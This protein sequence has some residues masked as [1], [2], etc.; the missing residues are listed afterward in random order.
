[1]NNPS[2]SAGSGLLW[3]CPTSHLD[4]DWLDT[5]AEYFEVGPPDPDD[6]GYVGAAKDILTGVCQLLRAQ[7]DF[8]YSLAEVAYLRAYLAV[9]PGDLATLQ[10]A[11]KGPGPNRFELIGGGI[12]S[13]DNLVCHGEVFIRNYLL[14]RRW[15]E[16][17]G[18]SANVIP[19][20]W[21]PDDFGHDPQLPVV[22]NAMGLSWLG[23]SRV[24]GSIQPFANQPLQPPD[25]LVIPSVADVLKSEG[26]VFPWIASDGSQV[27]THF[28]PATYGAVWDGEPDH[29]GSL[30]DFAESTINGWP[31]VNGIGRVLFAPAGGDFAFAQWDG[32][33][34]Q[35]F[36]EYYSKTKKSG[37]PDAQF[38]TFAQFMVQVAASAGPARSPL[39][40]Q[41][42]WTGIFASRPALKILHNRAAQ[43]T[44]AAEA[45]ATLLRLTGTNST[46]T[47]DDLDAAV[48]Q[49][50]QAL[51][52]S[53]HHDYITGTSPDR[54][55]WGEQLPMLEQAARLAQ[56]SL[57]QAVG[58]IAAGLPAGPGGSTPVAI[59]N[60]V[61]FTRQGGVVE[62]PAESV[63]ASV[64]EVTI[65][66]AG[67]VRIQRAA[68]G[69]LLILLPDNISLDSFGYVTAALREGKEPPAPS[70]PS[71]P[72][73][74]V[75]LNSDRVHVRID[76]SQAWAITQLA[77]PGVPGFAG[78]GNSIRLYEDDGN[79]YQFG[80]EPLKLGVFLK[81]AD[82]GTVLTAGPG[83][84]IEYG[85]VRWHF[86]ATV[87]GTYTNTSENESQ[88]VSY[89]LD[90]LLYAG[91]AAV[92]MRLT[93]ATPAQA[94][95]VT[96]FD[97]PPAFATTGLTY[98]TANHFDDHDPVAY[99][100]P[101][102]F[103]ATH[104]FVQPGPATGPGP[105]LA[106]YH[107]GVP[108]WSICDG[109][110]IGAL[111]RNT[112]G[113]DTY[114]RGASGTDPGV[115]TLEYALG[116]AFYP[117]ASGDTLRA[118][119]AVTNP[120]AGTVGD[121]NQ[122][123]NNLISLPQQ[124]GLT[125]VQRAGGTTAILRAARTQAGSSVISLSDYYAERMSFILRVYLPDPAAVGDQM[126][127]TLPSLPNPGIDGYT[128][129]LTA[130]IVSALEEPLA[131][132]PP[133]TV[134]PGSATGNTVPYTIT[135]TPK[136]ALTTIQ[137]SSTRWPTRG[138]KSGF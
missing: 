32:G 110:L 52:P 36:L 14:G 129:D 116:P 136:Q 76:P 37:D 28:M 69:G 75:D 81:F 134:T 62:L 41:N 113:L 127:I 8:C 7:P 107:Q 38:G 55:Y 53:S 96:A 78:V 15:L 95:V 135:F 47:L 132:A 123:V 12:T 89:T 42:Y 61:G 24:P 68:D 91:E 104:D 59:F 94:T 31:V 93:G 66:L 44:I 45:A 117:A 49:A 86:Q 74:P 124:A 122:P 84:W 60:P 35:A 54:V 130:V 121:P 109:Q 77:C 27:L 100:Q 103:R 2:S 18:L 23:I 65:G 56:Q 106:M 137:L 88:A 46:T 48:D 17:V 138:L 19:A 131:S 108:A 101:P 22:L 87:T 29:L 79:I 6:L 97:L 72:P 115:H 80:N 3:V 16:S 67:G 102:T 70:L 90:Y 133:V 33:N 21:L 126:T 26:L 20:A 64:S 40:A 114:Q 73:G 92:R 4:W 5:F 128:P 119:L 120:L 58:L 1:M 118:A 51:V 57:T 125:T 25:G 85:P 99:W 71:V 13:P 83:T 98:G 111:M 10:S 82:S 39:L 63:P 43:L 9:S 34:W 30:G 112:F 105:G 50:W 11:G